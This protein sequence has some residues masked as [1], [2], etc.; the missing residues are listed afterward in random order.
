LWDLVEHSSHEIGDGWCGAEV[1]P[2]FPR[3]RQGGCVKV[4]LLFGRKASQT[5]CHWRASGSVLRLSKISTSGFVELLW[6]AACFFCDRLAGRRKPRNRCQLGLLSQLCLFW[7]KCG[8]H[9]K[10]L[11]NRV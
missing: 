11:E 8:L 5:V 1:S 6:Y 10:S 9:K 7:Q 4:P 3:A 2:L